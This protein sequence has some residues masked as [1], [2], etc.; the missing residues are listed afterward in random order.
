MK[1]KITAIFLCVAL[2]AIAVVGASLAYFTD[3][4]SAENT[5]TVGNVAIK[6]DETDITNPE[7]ARVTS[8]TYTGV[9]PGVSY[10]KD[11]IVTNTGANDAW[12]RLTVTVENGM[13]WLGL[14]NEN[15]WNAP[16]EEAFMAMINETLGGKWSL[17]NIAYVSNATRGTTDFVATLKYAEKLPAGEATTAAFSEIILP[18]TATASDITTRISQ[19]GQFHIDVIAEAIQAD[20][21]GTWEDAF[22]AF[23]AK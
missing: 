8:N 20:T 19:N 9:T 13:N 6:L 22:T 18:A 4:K 3:T 7:G 15:V 23:D 1:K 14:Y 17:E 10:T 2:V 16:Q 21:F 12:V 5:F 11:P